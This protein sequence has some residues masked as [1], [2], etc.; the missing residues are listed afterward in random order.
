MVDYFVDV[1]Q[2]YLFDHATDAGADVC[3]CASCDRLR[4]LLARLEEH[5]VSPEM[6][7][8]SP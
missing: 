3:K 5:R 4:E 1:L 8:A 7:A 6:E 2:A